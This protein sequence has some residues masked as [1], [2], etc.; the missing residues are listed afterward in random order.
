MACYEL[1]VIFQRA[2]LFELEVSISKPSS[3]KSKSIIGAVSVEL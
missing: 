1:V 2:I 3:E